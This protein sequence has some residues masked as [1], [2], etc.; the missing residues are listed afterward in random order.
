MKVEVCHEYYTPELLRA[1]PDKVYVFGDNMIRKG[2][3]GQAIIRDE[4]NA[5]GISTKRYP[6][7][8]PGAFYAD[9]E[10]ELERLRGDLWELWLILKSGKTVVFPCDGVG[11]GLAKLKD[12]SPTIWRELTRELLMSFGFDNGGDNEFQKN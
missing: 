1:N 10:D 9:R 5:F 4:P 12:N 6:S 8:K 7:M 3:G 11:T 2:H